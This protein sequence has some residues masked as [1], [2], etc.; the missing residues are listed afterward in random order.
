MQ[1]KEGKIIDRREMLR[2]KVKSLAEESRIIRK[3]EGR[4]KGQIQYELH[5]HRVIDVRIAARHA[6]LAY[7][8]IKGRSID[9]M[10]NG[11]KSPPKWIEVRRLLKK[12]GPTGVEWGIPGAPEKDPEPQPHRGIMERVFG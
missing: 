12:Y 3:E 1:D 2:V 7:G 6:H 4:T 9:R 8:L 10:E 5:R 11:A